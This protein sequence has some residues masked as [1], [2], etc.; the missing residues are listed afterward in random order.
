MN[1]DI[2]NL[3]STLENLGLTQEQITE[4]ISALPDEKIEVPLPEKKE[5]IIED[6]KTR[7]LTEKDWRK[8]ASMSARII[9]LE[10]D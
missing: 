5:L 10:L 8:K 2:D 1:I 7:I 4:A 9:S 3:S 6:L